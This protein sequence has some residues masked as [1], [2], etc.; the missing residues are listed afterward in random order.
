MSL[1]SHAGVSSLNGEYK[2]R[3]CNDA[4]RTKVLQ[5][6]GHKDID[7]I[8]LSEPM[9]KEAAVA[10]LV[11]ID[12]ANKGGK[13]NKAVQAALEAAADKRGITAATAKTKPVT[14]KVTAKAPAKKAVA[15]KAEPAVAV[16]TEAQAIEVI[17]AELGE[18]LM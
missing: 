4:F 16:Q 13:V 5:K 1:Y 8:E 15:V 17:K 14:K 10:F 3:F 18:A 9:T 6:N 12:F 7:I 11:S 2:V